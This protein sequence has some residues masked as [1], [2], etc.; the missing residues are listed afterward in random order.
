MLAWAEIMELFTTK[1]CE[2]KNDTLEN[3]FSNQSLSQL[4]QEIFIMSFRVE[5]QLPDC[6]FSTTGILIIDESLHHLKK[7]VMY[8]YNMVVVQTLRKSSSNPKLKNSFF[9]KTLQGLTPR[10]IG[11]LIQVVKLGTKIEEVFIHF[12]L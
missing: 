6:I 8:I 7:I 5:N 10:L 2:S 9:F 1:F 11:S 4:F 3:L 12:F